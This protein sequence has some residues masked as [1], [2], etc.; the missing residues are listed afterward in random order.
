V[1]ALDGQKVRLTQALNAV[2]GDNKKGA[3]STLTLVMTP[4]FGISGLFAHN[5]VRGSEAYVTP[6]TTFP[7]AVE[8]TVSVE[9]AGNDTSFAH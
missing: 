2:D 6:E 3:A 4:L 5:F 8:Q 9:S 1:Y 7:V